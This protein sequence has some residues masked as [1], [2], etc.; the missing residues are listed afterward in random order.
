MTTGARRQE[1]SQPV[2]PGRARMFFL[3]F[4]GDRQSGHAGGA[5]QGAAHLALSRE[6]LG[7]GGRKVI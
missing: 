6:K 2:S 4:V 7:E 5:S 3:D 1:S